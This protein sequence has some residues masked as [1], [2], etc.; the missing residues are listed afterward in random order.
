MAIALLPA[1]KGYREL[2]V[3]LAISGI[4]LLL[5][6]VSIKLHRVIPRKVVLRRGLLCS[7][8][9]LDGKINGV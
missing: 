1:A 3:V 7:L 9:F 2:G 4:M 8:I 5:M 6:G